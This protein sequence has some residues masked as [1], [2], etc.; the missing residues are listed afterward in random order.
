MV[1]TT[2]KNPNNVYILNKIGREVCC[3]GHTNEIWLW[4]KRMGH[5]SFDNLVKVN[6]NHAVRGLPKIIKPSNPGCK[7]CQHGKQTKVRLK[8]QWKHS[9]LNI[10]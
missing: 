10:L 3:V 4:N 5:L 6:N 2:I 8:F 7:H 9:N 1:K